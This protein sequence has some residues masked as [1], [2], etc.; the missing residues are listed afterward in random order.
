M[1][2]LAPNLF[3]RR[4]ADFMDMGRARLPSLAP[5]WTD[6]NA[7]D[8][9]IT[10]MELLAW[11]AEAQLYS[12][13]RMR[14]DER[15]AYA[16]LLGLVPAGTQGATGLIWSDPHD[17]AAPVKTFAKPVVLATDT[18]INVVDIATPTFRPI[19]KL[20]WVPGVIESLVTRAPEGRTTDHTTTN[21]HGSTTFLPFGDK[22]GRRDVLVMKF[23]CRHDHGIFGDMRPNER[24]GARWAIGVQAAPSR[25]GTAIETFESVRGDQTPLEA[26]LV[27]GERRVPLKIVSDSTRGLLTTGA[28]LLDLD[29]VVNSPREVTI[30]LQAVNGFPRPPR[31]LRIEPNVIPV[32]QGRTIS[33]ELHEASGMPD[34]SFTLEETGL[35]F[36]RGEEPLALSVVEP[37]GEKPWLRCDRLSEQGPQDDVY[38]LNT[39]TGDVTFGNGV[40]GRIPTTGSQVLVSYA[41]S[42]GEEGAVARNRKWTVTGLDGVF[43]V[44][45]DPIGGGTSPTEW[46]GERREARRRSKADHAL[47]SEDDLVDAAQSLPLLDVA[48]AWVS[49]PDERVPR[50]GAVQL[51][52][53]RSRA[54]GEESGAVPETKRWLE[55]IQRRLIDRMP[56]GTRLVVVAP[57]YME[58]SIQAVIETHPGRDPLVVTQGI[59]KQLRNR[60]ALVEVGTD[61]PIRQPGVPVTQRDLAAWIRAT[62]G[63]RR[64]IEL[65]MVR[66]GQI[67]KDV[68]VPHDGLPRWDATRSTIHVKRPAAGGAR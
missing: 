7:H 8:P 48:R 50:T 47:V 57:R 5:D 29:H 11:S 65:R 4:F 32:R 54:S 12:L 3:D 27:D 36:G 1:S 19:D 68:F 6:H 18:V 59:E 33:R 22:A 25:E 62:D 31:L 34:W 46:I 66:D 41:V 52:V 55:A 17:P 42:D 56:L 58:F 45:V 49:K 16:A 20:L 67:V 14:R 10:L 63:V 64:V 37:I 26:V 53:L 23:R 21:E 2:G 51:V 15:L 61:I 43:G 28:L 44:N 35:R 24:V 30:E 39:V 13:A 9:G 60:L 40:N 38:E